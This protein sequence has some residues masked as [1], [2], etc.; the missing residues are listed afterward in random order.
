VAK[1]L[2]SVQNELISSPPKSVVFTTPAKKHKVLSIL[3]KYSLI[4]SML[5]EIASIT[6]GCGNQWRF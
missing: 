6:A 5:K 3:Q 1:E 4:L 2:P